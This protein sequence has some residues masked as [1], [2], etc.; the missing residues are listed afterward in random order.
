M[1]STT[2]WQ[3]SGLKFHCHLKEMWSFGLLILE[4]QGLKKMLLWSFYMQVPPLMKLCSSHGTAVLALTLNEITTLYYDFV[5]RWSHFFWHQTRWCQL[6]LFCGRTIIV[7]CRLISNWTFFRNPRQ[8]LGA[9][10]I[11]S[12]KLLFQCGEKNNRKRN[13]SY[14]F[15]YWS[16]SHS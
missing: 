8:V 11:L 3:H 13:I 7:R 5:V 9:W 16:L 15:E 14:V 6:E 4:S 10:N 1:L 2:D 12:K